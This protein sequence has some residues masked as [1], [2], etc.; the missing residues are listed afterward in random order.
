MKVTAELIVEKNEI[1][2]IGGYIEI[3]ERANCKIKVKEIKYMNPYQ[4][5]DAPSK[6]TKLMIRLFIDGEIVVCD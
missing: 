6:E 5:R 4:I 1:P 3:N 2:D